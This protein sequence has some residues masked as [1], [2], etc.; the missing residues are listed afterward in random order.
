M[1]LFVASPP[2]YAPLPP[3]VTPL[4]GA[5]RI[6]GGTLYA[7]PQGEGTQ[8]GLLLVTEQ[9]GAEVGNAPLALLRECRRRRFGGVAVPFAAP[10]LVEA[11]QRPLHEAGLALWVSEADAHLAPES[12]VLV[13]TALSGGEVQT[14]LEA[15]C[16]AY[17]AERI[18]LDVQ[19]L[20]MVFPLPCPTGEGTPLSAAA[21]D[22]L[23]QGQTVYYSRE[24]GMRYFTCRRQGKTV[25]VL[26]DDADTLARKLALGREMHI[27]RALLTLPESSDVLAA[28]LTKKAEPETRSGS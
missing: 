25:F 14:L 19:R 9:R 12:R 4:R 7:L 8:G 10:A 22:R 28:V 1:R 20:R 3:H 27:P 5:Y 15:A 26:F 13:N 23:G 6:E 21:L 11:L 17:G 16:R 18:V 2:P 24:L